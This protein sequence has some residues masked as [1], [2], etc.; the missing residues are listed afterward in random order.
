MAVRG[1]RVPGRSVVGL[2]W[3]AGKTE[4]GASMRLLRNLGGSSDGFLID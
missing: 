1:V 4:V 3:L 2:G